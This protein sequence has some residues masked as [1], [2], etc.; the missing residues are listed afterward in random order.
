[1]S[2][3]AGRAALYQDYVEMLNEMVRDRNQHVRESPDCGGAPF[4]LGPS[5]MIAFTALA[6][7]RPAVIADLC[8]VAVG[9]I[10]RLTAATS[11]VRKRLDAQR[12]VSADLNRQ[13]EILTDERDA[14]LLAKD[15]AES[16]AG[17][18]RAELTVW[19]ESADALGPVGLPLEEE[20]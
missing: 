3:A 5:E 11:E 20:R 18:L 6:M 16:E 2:T 1:M 13:V 7:A 8:L 10:D 14:A 19:E 12:A 17:A 4:C 9:E 15:A